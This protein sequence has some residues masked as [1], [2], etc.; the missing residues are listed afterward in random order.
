[1]SRTAAATVAVAAALLLAGVLAAA[2]P[3]DSGPPADTTA[4]VTAPAV[5][6]DGVTIAGIPVGG[7]PVEDAYAAVRAAFTTPVTLVVHG[8]QIDVAPPLLG[9]VGYAQRAVAAAQR[10][11]PGEVVPLQVSVR[12]GPLRRYL[13]TLARRLDRRPVDAILSLRRGK[14]WVSQERPGFAIDQAAAA[15]AISTE[16]DAGL[17][18]K[19]TLPLTPIAPAVTRADIGPV[20]VI[21]RGANRLNLYSGMRPVRTFQVATGQSR[22]PTPLGRFAVIVKWKN[23]WWYPP[24]APWAQGEKPT[25]PGPG[26]PLGTRW[27]G[28]SSPGVG[29]HGTPEAGSI[30]YSLSHGCIRMRIPEAEWLYDHV[31]V[32]TPV[33]IVAS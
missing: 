7:L 24:A 1:M 30:G 28:I 2:G 3:A 10:A 6:P 23:P 26:N 17:R 32:G 5:V 25:P 21:H 18:D 20:V 29:I 11:T 33:Y 16:L 4:T 14:P 12:P 27:M 13:Q 9:A 19:L 31:A 22:Y 15:D 8:R